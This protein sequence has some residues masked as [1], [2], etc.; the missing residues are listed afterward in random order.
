MPSPPL[1]SQEAMHSSVLKIYFKIHFHVYN[2]KVIPYVNLSYHYSVRDGEP[3]PHVH[4]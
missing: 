4:T 1:K 3:C 2:Q